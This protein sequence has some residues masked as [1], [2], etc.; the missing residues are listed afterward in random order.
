MSTTG[1]GVSVIIPVFNAERHLLSTVASAVRQNP[2]PLEIIIVDDGST[3]GSAAIA[4]RCPGPVRYLFQ[5]NAG[6]PAARNTGLSLARGE[7]IAFLDADDLWSEDRL[8]VQLGVL[9]LHP[10]ADL[11]AGRF[12]WVRDAALPG[13]PPRL[14]PLAN[15][16][17]PLSLGTALI[18]RHLFTTVGG[19]DESL[20]YND[21]VDWYLRARELGISMVLHEDVVLWYRRH[22]R[23][24]TND[25]ARGRQFYLTALK[26]SLDRRRARPDLPAVPLPGWEDFTGQPWPI[27]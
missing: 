6:P 7:L 21:D 27:R 22:E 3:D 18:R 1:P 9:A 4:A 15:P 25:V 14:T 11:V 24:I 5:P 17:N 16:R 2:G 12:Q 23:N 13:E 20:W 26:K 10:G 19:L 8:E